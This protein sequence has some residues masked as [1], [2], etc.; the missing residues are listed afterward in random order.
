MTSTVVVAVE[1]MEL[2]STPSPFIVSPSGWAAMVNHKVHGDLVLS[3]TP[4]I[5]EYSQPCTVAS[6]ESGS[7]IVVTHQTIAS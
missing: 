4:M 1:V 5:A 2:L 6:V 3:E 7:A